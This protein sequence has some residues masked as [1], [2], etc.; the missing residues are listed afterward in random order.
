MIFDLFLRF[1]RFFL[2]CFNNG[3]VDEAPE[4][5]DDDEEEVRDDELVEDGGGGARGGGDGE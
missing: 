4:D 3:R 2:L 5:A 1:L